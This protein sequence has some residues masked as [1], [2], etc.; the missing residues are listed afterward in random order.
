MFRKKPA[1][2]IPA[3]IA[4]TGSADRSRRS[5]HNTDQAINPVPEQFLKIA[6][7]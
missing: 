4:V 6:V 1:V 3:A 2:D 5:I 7:G